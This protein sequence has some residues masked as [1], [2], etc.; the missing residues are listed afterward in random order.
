MFQKVLVAEDMDNINKGME[1]TLSELGIATID[2]VQ[3]CDDAYLKI[4][5]ALL[6]NAPYEL[7]ITDLS[8]KKDYRKQKLSSG[9][10]LIDILK[11]AH[12]ELNIIVYSVEDKPQKVRNLINIY[13]INAYVCKGREG[14]KELSEAIQLVYNDKPFFSP[15]IAKALS[16]SYD[17]DVSDYNIQLIKLLSQG[18]S[19]H[20]IS[21]FLKIRNTFPNSLSTVEKRIN[22]LKDQFRANNTTH[23]V[24]IAKDLGLI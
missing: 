20:E 15:Q 17:P 14:L 23:L 6:D 2:Q 10:A 9:E 5:R 24:S 13:H 8:F 12:P 7:V 19:Q 3:Y 21:R 22:A 18:L 11:I 4:K 1:T 16:N